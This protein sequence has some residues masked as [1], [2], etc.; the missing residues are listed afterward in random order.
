MKITILDLNPGEEEEI[1][2]KCNEVNDDLQKLLNQLKQG[3]GKIAAYQ[4]GDIFFLEP[5]QIYYFESVDQKVFA[6]GKTNVYEVKSKL[7]ELEEQLPGGDFMRASKSTILNLNKISRLTPAFSGRFE[8]LL[9]NG[10]KAII[11][12]QYVSV[13]KERLGISGRFL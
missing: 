1:I 3:N 7:Y 2:V 4:N 11:S 5:E 13:L 10:E 8:A 9:Q 6:Y 12:R